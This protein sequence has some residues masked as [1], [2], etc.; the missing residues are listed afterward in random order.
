MSKSGLVADVVVGV[1]GA[2]VTGWNHDWSE[3]IAL[4][5]IAIVGALFLCGQRTRGGGGR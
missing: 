2:V 4:M 5:L 3:M 1:I